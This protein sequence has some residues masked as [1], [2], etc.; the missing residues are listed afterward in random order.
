[1]CSR[2]AM[3]RLACEGGSSYGQS[4]RQ[5]DKMRFFRGG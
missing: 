4:A 1:L 3:L 5:A 2:P